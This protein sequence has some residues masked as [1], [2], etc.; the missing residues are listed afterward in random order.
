MIIKFLAVP[1]VADPL[2]VP[3]N[4]EVLGLL[5]ES[6][7][8]DGPGDPRAM[9]AL[10]PDVQPP[11]SPM[12]EYMAGR[13]LRAERREQ[14]A[15]EPLS[16]RTRLSERLRRASPRRAAAGPQQEPSLPPSPM[17][18]FVAG[19]AEWQEQA[20]S[21]Q[22]TTTQQEQELQLEQGQEAEVEEEAE[23]EAEAEVEAEEEAEA[24]VEA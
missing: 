23:E 21:V 11:Y 24:E 9:H 14:E 15:S 1:R 6:R 7:G 18:E 4:A 5:D 12:A 8:S 16:E 22:A 10:A 19:R 17:A 2:G 13:A 20:R 3:G